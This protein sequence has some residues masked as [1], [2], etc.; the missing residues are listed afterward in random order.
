MINATTSTDDQLRF[1]IRVSGLAIYLDNFALIRLA[2]ENPSRRARFIAAM[3]SGAE[4]LFS[5]TNAA[6]LSGPQGRSQTLLRCFLDE[7]GPHWFP[8]ELDP[9][10]VVHR[11]LAGSDPSQACVSEDFLRGYFVA[12]TRDYVPGCGRIIDLSPGFF[13]LGPVLD[14]VAPQRDSIRRGMETLD[15]ALRARIGHYVQEQKT[16]PRWLESKFPAMPFDASRRATFTY[17]NLI[18]TLI[19][20]SKSYRLKKGDGGD[21]CHAMIAS[22]FASLATLDK[23]WK[24]RIESLPKPNH[25]AR[26]YYAQEL[27]T[28]V[29][30]L[31]SLVRT[32]PV[33]SGAPGAKG[34]SALETRSTIDGLS[35]DSGRTVKE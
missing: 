7:I 31:E 10:V 15:V 6:E 32:K 22:A 18:R 19:L 14:W 4:L 16:N 24:R 20:E 25:L 3:R 27:D 29:S 1:N 28:M 34:T 5:V 8:V 30:D 23:H 11:E 26:L 12:M 2:R 13:R 17:V 9:L 35:H 21:F 33:A